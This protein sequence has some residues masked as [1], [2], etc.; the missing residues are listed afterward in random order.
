MMSW[1][2]HSSRA[3][4]IPAA[5][6]TLAPQGLQYLH[7]YQLSFV[8]FVATVALIRFMG[9][10]KWGIPKAPWVSTVKWSNDLD[11]LGPPF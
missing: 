10:L 6:C 2:R 11:D 5:L 3:G 7:G 4:A 1:F 8:A 9:F